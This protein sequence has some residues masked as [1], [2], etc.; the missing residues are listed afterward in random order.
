MDNKTKTKIDAERVVAMVV[1]AP[2]IVMGVASLFTSN[3]PYAQY[4]MGGIVALGVV[5]LVL[6]KK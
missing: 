5:Y 2:F 4:I 3:V 6:H 1:A